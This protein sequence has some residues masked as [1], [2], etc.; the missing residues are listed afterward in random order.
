MS[1]YYSRHI[2]A[3]PGSG[4]EICVP[5]ACALGFLPYWPS[6][7]GFNLW[8]PGIPL[9]VL[10]GCVTWASAILLVF[11]FGA[12]PLVGFLDAPPGPPPR[13]YILGFLLCCGCHGG[14]PLVVSVVS[15]VGVALD[16]RPEFFPRACALGLLPR[17]PSVVRFNL[18]CPGIP[19]LVLFG[20]VTRVPYFLSFFLVLCP[21]W[22]L[23]PK[24]HCSLI[25]WSSVIKHLDN[26][27]IICRKNKSA[28]SEAIRYG[29]N[30]CV[31][32]VI[33]GVR[34]KYGAVGCSVIQW[35]A[36][37]RSRSSYYPPISCVYKLGNESGETA[38]KLD[39]TENPRLFKKYT[40]SP[41]AAKLKKIGNP[42]P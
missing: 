33:G 30:S 39:S 14:A 42:P 4:N 16:A 5:R 13:V 8:C 12:V 37:S 38:C 40:S 19:R 35:F 24:T 17:W 7:V 20:C 36:A 21:W 23:L 31:M 1:Q 11:F 28:I 27:L 22:G 29:Q 3:R 10:F 9:L 41:W 34:G 18:W 32:R 2:S 15:R 6:V 25:V 26:T